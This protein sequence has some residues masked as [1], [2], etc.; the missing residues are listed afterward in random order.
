MINSLSGKTP[1]QEP[2]RA[3]IL[4]KNPITRPK[5]ITS[6]FNKQFT[7]IVNH[8]TNKSYRMTDR[9]IKSLPNI[10]HTPITEQQ[11]K[12]SIQESKNNNSTGS[13]NINIKYLKHLGP[14]AIS[15]LTYTYNQAI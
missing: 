11:V 15:L 12:K 6:K 14:K 4:D 13:D 2:N 8:K 3:I 1:K 5:Q 10:N 7:T 9:R